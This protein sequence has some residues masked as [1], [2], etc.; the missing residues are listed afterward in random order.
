MRIK[1]TQGSFFVRGDVAAALIDEVAS[2]DF[3]FTTEL[4]YRAMKCSWEII[5][6]PV[7]LRPETR[8]STVR[9]IRDSWR[10]VKGLV[11][12]WISSS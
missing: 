5:E 9:P 3:F 7:K 12:L 6:V 2:R 10:M 8:R 11:R 1:D 4:C